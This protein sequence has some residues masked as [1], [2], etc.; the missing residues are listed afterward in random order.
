MGVRDGVEAEAAPRV[1]AGD[2]AEREPEAARRTVRFNGL[3]GVGG[4]GRRKAAGASGQRRHAHLIGAYECD[5]QRVSHAARPAAFRHPD[6][7]VR[8]AWRQ[9]CRACRR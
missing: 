6:V 3:E 1:A 2:P 8:L 5:R 9:V 7:G 4:A